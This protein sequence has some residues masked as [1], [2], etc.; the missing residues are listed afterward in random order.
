[1]L[2]NGYATVC[3][4]Q[5]LS[6]SFAGGCAV[7]PWIAMLNDRDSTEKMNT[8]HLTQAGAHVRL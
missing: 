8:E 5:L 6:T 2:K 7:L 4:L 3:S 1:M